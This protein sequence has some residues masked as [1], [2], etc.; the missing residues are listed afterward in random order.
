MSILR[1]VLGLAG[2]AKDPLKM[3]AE[4]RVLEAYY[5]RLTAFAVDKSRVIAVE[6]SSADPELA[7]NAANAIAEAYLELQ[8]RA[9]QDQTRMAGQ[10]LGGEIETLRRK[11]AEAEAKVEAVPRQV[12]PVH[13]HQQ[14]LAVEPAD[15][16][17]QLAARAR[18]LAEGGGRGQGAADPRP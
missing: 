13:R 11:V 7:A 8:Q 14:H 2:L 6:F 16:R 10:W 1:H 9:K 4:E 15:G 17:A 5:E 12:Q 3:T 18:P